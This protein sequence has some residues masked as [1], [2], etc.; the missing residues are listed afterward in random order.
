MHVAG[1]FD[2]PIRGDD[3]VVGVYGKGLLRT[4]LR[5]SKH[6]PR[7]SAG[8]KNLDL[9][10]GTKDQRASAGEIDSEAAFVRTEPVAAE[11][12]ETVAGEADRSGDDAVMGGNVAY[13]NGCLIERS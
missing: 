8:S 1:H 9:R 11:E 7:A 3:D 10:V 12:D 6:D 4:A 2:S 13:G 5:E